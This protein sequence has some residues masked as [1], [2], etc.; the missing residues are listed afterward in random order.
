MVQARDAVPER[1]KRVRRDQVSMT[2]REIAEALMAGKAV[3]AT[4]KQYR[5]SGGC[6]GSATVLWWSALAI[7]RV[8]QLSGRRGST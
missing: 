1:G 3:A 8:R 4:R 7:E 2:A 6:F 5:P